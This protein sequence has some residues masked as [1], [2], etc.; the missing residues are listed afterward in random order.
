MEAIKSKKLWSL[1]VSCLLLIG[2]LVPMA[3][4]AA[5][6]VTVET[7]AGQADKWSYND[8]NGWTELNSPWHYIVNDS[9]ST[10][11]VGYCLQHKL[12]SPH[13]DDSYNSFDP[14]TYF[15]ARTIAGLQIIME[16]GYPAQ[17]PFGTTSSEEAHYATSNAIRMWL[18]EETGGPNEFCYAFTNMKGED[19]E[20][21]YESCKV[22][23]KIDATSTASTKRSFRAA[24][25]LLQAARSQSAPV[26]DITISPSSIEMERSGDYYV[27]TA[28]IELNGVDS[29][30]IDMDVLPKG[31]VVLDSSGKQITSGTKSMEVTVKVPRNGNA[32][33]DITLVAYG[34][35]ENFPGNLL[36]I[37]SGRSSSQDILY[38]ANE[39]KGQTE[40]SA[41]MS[42]PRY[43][44]LEVKKQDAETADE[45]QGDALLEGMVVEIVANENIPE[46]GLSKGDV[47]Q[48]LKLT[49][50]T[51]AKSKEL[52]QGKYL[53]REVGVPTGYLINVE[54][55][56]VTVEADETQQ[57]I[58]KDTVIKAPISIVKFI[59][60]PLDGEAEN[61][62]I[63]DPESGA[64][65]EVT[66]NSSG[67][68]YDTIKTDEN[69]YA[70]TKPLPYGKYTVTQISGKDGYKF[71]DPFEVEISEN[72][73]D[74]PIPYIIENTVIHNVVRIV[75]VDAESGQPIV[76]E[77]VKFKI[78]DLDTGEWVKQNM[79]YPE[80]VEIDVFETTSDG[81]LTLPEP[82]RYGKYELH[83]I[84]SPYPYLLLTEPVQ[85]EISDKEATEI[86]IVV[87]NEIVKGQIDIKKT[88]EMFVGV[89]EEELEDGTIVKHPVFEE[90][91]LA[92]VEF[93]IVAAEQ[94]VSGDGVV[95]AEA[96]DVV[97][98]IVTGNGES[99]LSD[100]LYLGKYVIREKST[101]DGFLLDQTEYPVELKY[102]D[103]KTPLVLETVSI[104][105]ERAD[106]A[107]EVLKDKEVFQ[108]GKYTYVPGEG[109]GFA[110]IAKE[111]L[112]GVED[113]ENPL[114][115]GGEV[116]SVA[117]TD[118][119]G[120]AVFTDDVPYSANYVVKEL[121]A[122]SNEFIMSEEEYPVDLSFNQDTP[123][124]DVKVNGGESIKNDLVK[125]P[126]QISKTDIT[127][128]VSLP[129]VTVEIYDEAGT[130]IYTGVTQSDGKTEEIELP[131]NHKYTYKE[132]K[133]VDGY[134]LNTQLMQF[135]ITEDGEVI[136]DMTIKD[137]VAK[138]ILL[139]MDANT[140]KPLAGVKF[141][142]YDETGNLV[143]EAISQE[144]GLVTFEGVKF[145]KWQ[146]KEISTVDGY[147]LSGEVIVVEVNET[148]ENPTAPIEFV[149]F[150][151]VQTGIEEFPW[152][153]VGIGCGCV[154]AVLF[155]AGLIQKKRKK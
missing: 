64:E 147:Q 100:E 10:D 15:S 122:P 13:A 60:E 105:N 82:L 136:G 19:L 121:Y 41:T 108:E 74:T 117:V 76:Q 57:V 55:H 137:E 67:E 96:G 93:E 138:I 49:G 14:S 37:T 131:V 79:L 97:Q 54:G 87:E 88:G 40:D 30:E 71:V 9:G 5:T 125:I 139:K 86:E 133:S 84:S 101:V 126:V 127:G 24:I 107:V 61:P 47:V 110:L 46:A 2:M 135:E 27:G 70:Q 48:T 35:I 129:G 69:G 90:R 23:G 44:W 95:H 26:H 59:D 102:E 94:I 116:V 146:I 50:T 32:A 12:P 85:F 56:G 119:D 53:V 1:L 145:G 111:D 154:A 36:W 120:K 4:N 140:K 113:S 33:K 22:P 142:L 89:E 31:T 58:I 78:K 91:P 141:G 155:V 21:A 3:G 80:P 134:A 7:A 16:L 6:Q 45:P 62:Q 75:K 128:E 63:K 104:K 99:N 28:Y 132:T 8:G 81:R 109:F 115:L 124:I 11:H 52:Y 20:A 42:T 39:T 123:V 152:L 149:N 18:S 77:G 83:E 148:Y 112:Y 150:P 72:S 151:V 17:Y 103:N 66:L 143:M 25:R 106:V 51:S 118:E 68:V 130:L 73:P 34:T 98:T 65:F 144:D 114:I 38:W 29:F 92:G 153:A 43:G